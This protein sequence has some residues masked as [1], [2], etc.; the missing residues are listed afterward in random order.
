M[1]KGRVQRG[2]G[3][4][5]LG[6]SEG[7]ASLGS[8]PWTLVPRGSPM[9]PNRLAVVQAQV[10]RGSLGSVAV[11]GVVELA[12]LEMLVMVQVTVPLQPEGCPGSPRPQVRVP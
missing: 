12:G 3:A 2:C 9:E 8:A 10:W 1:G 5:D 4:R 6:G 11:V 7:A